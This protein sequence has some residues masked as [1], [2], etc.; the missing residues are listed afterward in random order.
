MVS[1]G[2]VPARKF[3]ERFPTVCRFLVELFFPLWCVYWCV[4]VCVYRRWSIER[5]QKGMDFAPCDVGGCPLLCAPSISDRVQSRFE[6]VE[7]DRDMSFNCTRSHWDY[8]LLPP[9]TTLMLVVLYV[10]VYSVCRGI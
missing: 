7:L 1:C 8:G 3:P 5:H 9:G 2:Q 6:F 10:R 4:G